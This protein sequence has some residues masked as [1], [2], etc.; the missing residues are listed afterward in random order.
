MDA[1]DILTGNSSL[2]T[3]DAWEHLN[4][5]EGGGLGGYVLVDTVDVEIDTMGCVDIEIENPDIDVGVEPDIDVEVDSQELD[6]EIEC[7]E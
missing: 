5:Q 1:W 7:N 6:V 2:I 4:A 3:G